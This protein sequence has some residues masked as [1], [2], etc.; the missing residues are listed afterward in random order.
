MTK[1]AHSLVST[2]PFNQSFSHFPPSPHRSILPASIYDP[3]NKRPKPRSL[4]IIQLAGNAD[5][6]LSSLSQLVHQSQTRFIAEAIVS[7]SETKEP[8]TVK[9]MVESFIAGS[10]ENLLG[11]DP[12]KEGWLAAIRP[13]DLGMALN[14]IRGIKVMIKC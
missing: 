5:L 7:L 9:E 12:T 6:D 2:P 11:K 14:R 3:T 4:T 10:E 13:I 1:K 8:T